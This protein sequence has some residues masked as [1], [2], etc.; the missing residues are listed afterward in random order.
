MIMDGSYIS[1]STLISS[2]SH[3]PNTFSLPQTTEM[4]K[5]LCKVMDDVAKRKAVLSSISAEVDRSFT[6]FGG[7]IRYT[8][9]VVGTYP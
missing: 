3:T 5:Q 6:G 2:T 7:Q 1:P 9:E 4:D 8:I